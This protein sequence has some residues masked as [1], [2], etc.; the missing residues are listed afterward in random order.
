MTLVDPIGLIVTEIRDDATVAALTE[1]RVRGF[2]P[3]PKTK[4][5]EG[6]AQGTGKYK[7]H[8]VIVTLGRRRE[9]RLPVQEVRA[10]A[11]CYGIDGKDAARVGGAVSDA[12]HNAGPRISPGGV[13]VW[14]SWDDGGEGVLTDPDTAQPYETVVIQVNAADR[15]IS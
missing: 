6:D 12:I 5:Y 10:A 15:V 11:R 7:R 2:E 3:A 4:S 9:K 8:V 13:G 14:N 1:G